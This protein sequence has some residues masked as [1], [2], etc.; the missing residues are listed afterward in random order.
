[1]TEINAC[2]AASG[3]VD[4]L[5]CMNECFKKADAAKCQA[6]CNDTMSGPAQ[7]KLLACNDAKCHDEC[8]P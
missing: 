6:G 1:M 5:L 2:G 4:W 8:T 7:K 3:C